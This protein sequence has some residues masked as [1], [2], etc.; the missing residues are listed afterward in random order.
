MQLKKIETK[1]KSDLVFEQLRNNI[2]VGAWKPGER[3]PS[4]SKL[5][6]YTKASRVAVREAIQR[7]VGMGLLT[8]RQGDGTFVNT[9][10]LS[11][12][13]EGLLPV[14]QLDSPDYF[15][16]QEY[17]LITEP[18]VA[19]IAAQKAT[20]EDILA[21]RLSI[22]RQQN[23]ERGSDEYVEEDIHFHAI[24]A[25]CTKNSVFI[26]INRAIEGVRNA[27]IRQAAEK[28]QVDLS[29][30]FHSSILRAIENREPDKAEYAM[31]EHILTNIS[32]MKAGEAAEKSKE[33]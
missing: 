25:E 6:E 2:Y 3:I 30:P 32:E 20:K 27:A 23:Y 9:V 11:D 8:V 22:E 28:M 24:L 12:Y 15:E 33:A 4:E 1:N 7:L 14:L 21:L 5:V 19:R 26:A 18:Q 10:I 17:R 16:L 31:R 13:F 29:H